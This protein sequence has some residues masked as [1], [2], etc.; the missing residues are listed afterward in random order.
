MFCADDHLD[1]GKLQGIWE[2]EYINEYSSQLD[3]DDW[4]RLAISGTL[5]TDAY[6]RIYRFRTIDGERNEGLSAIQRSN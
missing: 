3:S 1:F 2:R 5:L 6:N 4:L